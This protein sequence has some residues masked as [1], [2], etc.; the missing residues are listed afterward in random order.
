VYEEYEMY[1]RD[2][3]PAVW[4]IDVRED[5]VREYGACPVR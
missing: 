3:R 4:E 2:E 1:E 5:G